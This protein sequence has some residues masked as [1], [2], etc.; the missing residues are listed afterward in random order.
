M[1]W[2]GLQYCRRIL[3]PRPGKYKQTENHPLNFSL[4]H[5]PQYEVENARGRERL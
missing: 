3:Q 2:C 4:F 1:G 5:Q